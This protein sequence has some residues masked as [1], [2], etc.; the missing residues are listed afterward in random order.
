MKDEKAYVKITLSKYIVERKTRMISREICQVI[1]LSKS[2]K[3]TPIIDEF[4]TSGKEYLIISS[5]F[6]YK[7]YMLSLIVSERRK[8]SKNIRINN[9]PFTLT[10][11]KNCL[12]K[13][14]NLNFPIEIMPLI[15]AIRE[16]VSN[17]VIKEGD[18]IPFKNPIALGAQ[19]YADQVAEWGN[20]WFS[21]WYTGPQVGQVTDFVILGVQVEAFF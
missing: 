4:V 15:K 9:V 7:N 14:I 21:F 1:H 3:T 8:F 19:T 2:S 20:D 5:I 10:E 11:L 17:Q 13:D 6:K 18:F 12:D 16:V